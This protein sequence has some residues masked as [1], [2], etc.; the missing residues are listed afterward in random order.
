MSLKVFLSLSFIDAKFVAEVRQR[1]PTGLAY[2]YEESFQNG[3]RLLDEMERTVEDALVFVLFASKRGQQSPWVGFE[4]DHARLQHIQ[5]RNHRILV[6]PTDHE[7][8][9]SDLPVWLRNHWI[10]RAGF[11]ASDIARYITGVLLEPNIG[12]STGAVRVIGRGKTLDRLEQLAADN[13]ARTRVSPNVYFLTGFRGVGRRTFA[14]YYIRNALASDANLAFGP[15][16]PLSA[17]AD[18]VDLFQALRAEISPVLPVET[19]LREREA[20]EQLPLEAQIGEIVR[21]I[22]HF[23]ALGQAVT[24]VSVGGFFEDRGDPKEWVTPLLSAI[25]KTAT[26]FIVS[27][28]QLLPE[29]VQSMSNVLQMRVDELDDKDIRA[30][31]IRAAERLRVDNFSVSNELVRAIGGHADVANAAVRLAAIKGVHILERDPRQ[32]FNIQNMILGE[33]IEDGSLTEPQRK[34]L[35]LLSWVP[36]L[37]GALLEKVVASEGLTAENFVD[38]I[39]DLILGCLVVATGSNFSISPA[40]RLV[41]RRFNVTPPELLRSFSQHLSE[42]WKTAQAKGE[43]RNDL[44]EAFV[45]MHALEGAALPPELRPLLTPGTLVD[46]LRENYARGKDDPKILA[47]VIRWGELSEQMKMSEATRE[48]VLS[49]V[50]RAHIRLGKYSDADRIIDAMSRKGYRSVPFLRGHSLRRQRD[51]GGAIELLVEATR[52]RKLN[53]SAVHELALAYKKSGRANELR[54]LLTKHKELIRDSAMFADFQIGVDLARNDFGAAEHAISR[55]RTMPD[56][57][58]MS[59]VRLAQLLMKRQNFREA[60]ELLT[61]LTGA[62]GANNI[63]IR[64]IRAVCAARDG[65]FQMAQQDIDFI[66]EFPAWNDATIHLKA[67]LLIEQRRPV[68]ARKLLDTLPSKGPEEWMLYARALDNEADMPNILLADAQESRRRAAELRAQYN[69]ALEYDFAD[70]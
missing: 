37:N 65:D 52:E 50:A 12:I 19:V 6:F 45:F 57:N 42:E 56:D 29:I 22:G 69:F 20:F 11:T 27:N 62:D 2:F 60:K 23:S 13:F 55:L 10:A 61:R 66:G 5:K 9:L 41:F 16:L 3:Q 36:S 26:L 38:A 14:S 67:S 43:F 51:Y 17:L 46:V 70:S 68:E 49:T 35:C 8:G 25:P 4:I 31:M 39:E 24:F 33:N 47:Q 15:T 30:L 54:K 44:F 34:I 53:R 21:L 58:G 59:D 7:V 64:S 63:R 40:I 1:L 28:R 18:L 48:E 32:L